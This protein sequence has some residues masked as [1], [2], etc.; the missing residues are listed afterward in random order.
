MSRRS[1]ELGIDRFIN[2]LTLGFLFLRYP[3]LERGK[4]FA[5]SNLIQTRF[6]SQGIEILKDQKCNFW[7]QSVESVMR[8]L[9]V[10]ELVLILVEVEDGVQRIHVIQEERFEVCLQH[11]P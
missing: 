7:L 6:L 3:L 2:L 10:G 8:L 4:N 11:E 5:E 1:K 9:G